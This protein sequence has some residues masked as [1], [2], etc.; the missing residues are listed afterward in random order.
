[1]SGVA[2]IQIAV[3]WINAVYILKI[4]GKLAIISKSAFMW[5]VLR[6]PMEFF[7]QRMAGDMTSRMPNE[8]ITSLLIKQLA[9]MLLDFIIMIFY[10][11]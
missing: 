1:M 9:P 3:A 7:S 8:G 6:L 4:E 2:V 11:L 5:N 10:I